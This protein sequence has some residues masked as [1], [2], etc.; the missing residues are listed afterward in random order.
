LLVSA[1]AVTSARI[2]QHQRIQMML[3]AGDVFLGNFAV[4]PHGLKHGE[5][6]LLLCLF[7]ISI[8][9]CNRGSTSTGTARLS[10]SMRVATWEF[11]HVLRTG[12]G[13]V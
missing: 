13:A 1:A 9:A 11:P 12:A 8:L 2:V 4:S 5:Y 6:A 3:A 7:H 10:F